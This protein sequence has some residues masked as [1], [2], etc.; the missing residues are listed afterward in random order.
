M[1]ARGE[2]RQTGAEIR[3]RL[4]LDNASTEDL[5]PGLANL[6]DEVVFGRVWARPGLALDERM[7]ATLSALTSKQHLPQLETFVGA[8]LH[9]G[10]DARLIQEVMLHCAMYSGLPTAENSL[11]IVSKVLAARGLAQL[12]ADLEEAD[13]DVL[14]AKGDETM[15]ALHGERAEGGYASPTSAASELYATAIEFLYGDVWNRPGISR[16]QRMI[17]SVAAFT[18]TQLEAQQ[19]KFFRSALNVGLSRSEILEVIIQTGPYSGFPLALNALAIAEDVL[20]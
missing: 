18:A 1:T 15:R 20:D 19:R 14:S 11:K 8:A 13:L 16:R 9:I 6:T 2:L 17:C 12:Q 7:L 10:L 3:A 4:G 5:L